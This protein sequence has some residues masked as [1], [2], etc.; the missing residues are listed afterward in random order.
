MHKRE[1]ETARMV[2]TSARLTAEEWREDDAFE[3]LTYEKVI[4][5]NTLL[6]IAWLSRG[7]ELAAPVCRIVAP[8]GNGS[9]FL[10]ANDL[11]LTNHHVLPD[12][13]S[14]AASTAEFNYQVNWAGDLEPVRRYTL[15]SAHF[16][17]SEALDY[18]IVRVKESPGDLFGFVDPTK[19]GQPTVNDFVS[20]IQHP[21]GGTKQ[22]CFTDNKVSAVFGDL[23]QYSTD[24]EPGSSG[25]P[26]FNQAWEIVGLHH[27]GGGLAG[28]DG[29]KYFTNE[30][31]QIASVMRDAAAFLGI[32]DGLYELAFADLRAELVGLIDAT[33]APPDPD[34]RARELLRTVPRFSSVI[35]DWSKLDARPGDAATL[36]LTIAGAA[37]GAA[38]RQWA[39]TDGHES[40]KAAAAVDPPPEPALVAL[41]SPFNGSAGLPSDVYAAV[42]AGLR[43]DPAPVAAIAA[44]AGPDGLAAA[45]RAFLRGVLAGA[46]AYD[47]PPTS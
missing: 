6:R 15:D 1:C 43:A 39:R 26:V 45:A 14:A 28:P 40:I 32:S 36:T 25:S 5:L 4:G 18:T 30:G 31:I 12:E 29:K 8:A 3:P 34:A 20:I 27:R 35:D 13:P 22:I 19:R 11:L 41:V 38:L 2:L 17:T 21:Q 47:P 44:A 23:V 16:R 7:L 24:T 9:G 33:A 42:L 10:I 46:K 37:I